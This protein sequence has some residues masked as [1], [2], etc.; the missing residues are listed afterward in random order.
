MTNVTLRDLET[1]VMLQ[2]NRMY[3][4]AL[5]NHKYAVDTTLSTA[6]FGATPSYISGMSNDDTL[7]S[8]PSQE[9]Q[10][11]LLPPVS[12]ARLE[13]QRVESKRANDTELFKKMLELD[14]LTLA[15]TKGYRIRAAYRLVRQFL[16]IKGQLTGW[17]RIQPVMDCAV[18]GTDISR[19]SLPTNVQLSEFLTGYRG[20]RNTLLAID[21]SKFRYTVNTAEGLR[22]FKGSTPLPPTLPD[23]LYG[24]NDPKELWAMRVDRYVP[25]DYDPRED[26]PLT[27][28]CEAMCL[29]AHQMTMQKGAPEEPWSGIYGLA[30]LLNPYTARM[31]W[32]TRDELVMFE[33]ELM[34]HVY[35]IATTMSELS[36]Q[37]YLRQFF[38]FTRWESVDITKAAI[39][40]GG[41]LY[42][43]QAEEQRSL[44][45]S[46]IERVIDKCS[47]SLD[48]RA[49]LAGIKLKAQ[50]LGLTANIENETM[51]TLRDASVGALRPPD[52]DEDPLD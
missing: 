37:N 39:Q 46:Q 27:L 24:T 45:L 18:Q 42:A 21:A 4:R 6:D 38:G 2:L 51:Q 33:E 44:V 41:M 35:D 29:I 31:A 13:F 12:E 50:I 32:P 47:T 1:S 52:E 25:P 8:T 40:A 17:S 26:L 48:P 22:A 43:A 28:Y 3:A 7:P 20:V 15:D 30:G 23:Q 5:T 9:A 16:R 10:T 14:N 36:T 19:W 49:E 11:G 34:L